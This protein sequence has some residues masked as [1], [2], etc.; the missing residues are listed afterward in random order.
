MQI[1]SFALCFVLI[2]A[3][4]S[5]AAVAA[6]ATMPAGLRETLSLDHDWRFFEG[7]VPFPKIM[8]H[9]PSYSNAK[10]GKA[11]GAAAPEF[12]DSD[13]KIVNLPHDWVVEQPFDP[14]ANLSQGF[15]DRG[16]AWY[17]RQIKLDPSDRGRHLELQFDGVATHCTVW[18]NGTLVHRNWCGYTSFYIDVTALATYG[19]QVNT[20]ALRDDADAMEGWWYEGGG[21]YR[22]TY[23]V[24]RDPLHVITDGVYANPVRQPDGH[25]TIPVEITVENTG[26]QVAQANVDVSVVDPD[27][28]EVARQ[29]AGASVNPLA[30]TVAKLSIPVAHPH[31][32]SIDD[33][34][35]YHVKTV[36]ERDNLPVDSIT[37]S[38]GFRTIRFDP[39]KGFFLNDQSVKIKGVCNHQ[40][41]AGVGVAI[42][43]SIIAFR[44]RRLKEMGVNA[45]RCSHNPPAKE[46][47]DLCDQMGILVMDENRNFNVSPECIGQLQWMVRRDRNHPSVILWSVFNEE[48]MQGTEQGYEM[49]RRMSAVV[50]TLDTSRPVTA[51]MSNGLETPIN[52]SQA[53]DVVGFNYQQGG[54]DSYHAAHP[55]RPITSSEDTSAVMTRGVFIEDRKHNVLDSYDDQHPG[56]GNTHHASWF[57]I[58]QRPFVAGCFCWTGFDYRGEPTPFGWPSASSSFGCMDLCGFPKTAYYLRQAQWIDDRPIL[59]LVPHWNW[60]GSEG[61]PI[62]VLALT[63]ADA[64]SLSL[65]GKLIEHKPVDPYKM[66]TWEVPYAPGRLEA[67]AFRGG[68]EVARY[69]V[70]TTGA[71]AAVKLIPDR[72]AMAGDGL[73]AIP[74][75]VEVVDDHG[76]ICPT[77]GNPIDFE[78]NGAAQIIGLGN[79]DPNCHEP[80]KGNHRSVFNGLAQVILQS[81]ENASGQL[82]LRATSPGLAPAQLTIDLTRASQPAWVPLAEPIVTLQRWRMAPPANHPI[83]PAME[84]ASNDMNTW[85]PV[86]A[87]RPQTLKGGQFTLLRVTFHP[88]SNVRK[89]GGE[90]VFK[91]VAGKAQVWQG[92]ILLGK[93]EIFESGPFSVALPPGDGDRTISV[94][95]EAEPGKPAGLAGSVLVNPQVNPPVNPR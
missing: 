44:L 49:A 70:E 12:D 85:T 25:W 1:H 5:S 54:Y 58:S 37:T 6:A 59:T 39:D 91:N 84:V 71:P 67:V 52:V 20:I 73:D 95:I 75:T 21:I 93:K 27:G 74:V 7:D 86:Q 29:S 10:A 15:R 32:W 23:L 66:V 82:T 30:Q 87:G 17:R 51:A 42:P 34:A 47:L 60:T 81:I 57:D 24:K 9:E 65:N 46:M 28:K 61:K 80:E 36:V 14:N 88:R 69:A 11:W 63:N 56:W 76:R 92:K 2:G 16:I 90:L 22:H 45:Y 3:G 79:G 41:H 26:T 72:S 31:L 38:C 18:F 55:T 89:D 94:Q 64:V 40:D 50:K 4:L 8:G 53:V 62:K 13:W 78:I 68:K 77:A 33:P 83:D 48:P 19:D 43:D 35:L